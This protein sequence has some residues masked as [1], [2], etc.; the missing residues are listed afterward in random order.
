MHQRV[1]R[2]RV[3]FR[4]GLHRPPLLAALGVVCLLFAPL[5]PRFMGGH[6]AAAVG[7]ADAGAVTPL[8]PVPASDPRFGVVQAYEAPD[9]ATKAGVSW[10]RLLF[11]WNHIQPGGPSDWHDD[12]TSDAQIAAEKAAGRQMAG[13]VLLTPGWA[14][15]DP[16]RGGISV[17]ANLSLPIADPRNYWAAFLMKLA[18]RYKG[19]IDS[20]I[21]WNEPDAYNARVTNNWA[22]TP[23]DY[24]QLL[25][26][27]YLAIKSVN[28][29]ATVVAAGQT[30]FWDKENGRA[31]FLD[32]MLSAADRD[33]TAAAH[34]DYFDAA[35]VHMYSNPLNTLLGPFFYHQIFAKHHIVKPIWMSELNVVPY[36]DPA[37]PLPATDWRATQDQ[38]ASYMIES[39][40]LALAAGVAR[41]AV[42]KMVDGPAEGAGE[43][44]GLVRNDRSPRPAYV[45]Y[46]LANR[47]FA[48]A[49]TAVYETG[50]AG[51]VPSGDP[52]ADEMAALLNSN[53]NR[54]QWIWPGA[55]NRVVITRG[56]QQITVVWDAADVPAVAEVP[57]TGGAATLYDKYGHT[58]PAPQLINGRYVLSLEGSTN[59]TDPR[60]AT[61]YLVGGSPYILVQNLAPT[62]T[63]PAAAPLP[64]SQAGSNG[65]PNTPTQGAARV[66]GDPAGSV[67]IDLTKHNVRGPFLHYFWANGGVDRFGYPRTEAFAEGKTTVQYFDRAVLELGADGQT[68][69]LRPLGALLGN[70]GKGFAPSTPAAGPGDTLYF[71]ATH[72]TLSGLFLQYWLA[73]DGRSWLGPPIS[74]QMPAPVVDS[75]TGQTSQTT[76]QYFRN[77]RLELHADIA[78]AHQIVIISTLGDDL[79]RQKGWL[80]PLP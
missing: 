24:Y 57:A 49:T 19:S 64:L 62:G 35:D 63:P 33:P 34:G 75:N 51:G 12:I 69:S 47:L 28:A 18:A 46:Q 32:S 77:W 4:S 26:V 7:P 70:G 65:M 42:Y 60:D 56:S 59:N 11:R 38:Q 3:P 41:F 9:L 39:A 45:A 10:E 68:I 79:L 22:G 1:V 76:V 40:A 48:N 37:S 29:A 53:L 25:K 43:L 27:A 50:A 16:Q 52:T 80:P 73:N 20:W 67:Y 55:V 54:Y 66:T 8:P 44:Y 21:V 2:L 71:A 15:R 6:H 17:P 72:H 36:D 5:A 58:L 61:L 13:V 14:A 74:E 30:F 78:G 23:A 31:Q